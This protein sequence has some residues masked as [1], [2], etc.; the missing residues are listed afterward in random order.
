[1]KK[2]RLPKNQQLLMPKEEPKSGM[3][4]SI[5]HS[6]VLYLCP[7]C[8]HSDYSFRFETKTK[9]GKPSKKYQ[10]PECHIFMRQESVTKNMTSKQYAEWVYLY[11]ASEFF[12]KIDYYKWSKRLKDYGIANDFWNKYRE[13]KASRGQS[14]EEHINE[15]AE[16]WIKQQQ[17]MEEE[18]KNG[19]LYESLF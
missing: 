10:C 8:L 18:N 9:S 6:T 13:L 14:Y 16:Q 3:T 7:F 15:E 2:K 11:P 17:K 1:M 5:Q 19:E 12:R 4:V